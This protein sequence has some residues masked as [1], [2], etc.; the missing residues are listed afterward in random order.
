MTEEKVQEEQQYGTIKI[1]DEAVATIASMAAAH[2]AGVAGMSG[3]MASGISEKL[4][5]K[6]LSKGVKVDVEDNTVVIALYLFVEFGVKI[7]Q[8]AHE[9]QNEVR[10]TVENMTGLQV[11]EVNIH[12]QGI[13]FETIEANEQEEIGE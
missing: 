5:K 1:A 13:S 8:L 9:I 6:N 10:N 2:V 7:P 3:G 4:G 12:V 11:K